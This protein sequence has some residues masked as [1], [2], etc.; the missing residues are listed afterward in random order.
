MTSELGKA[1]SL[2]EVRALVKHL[3]EKLARMAPGAMINGLTQVV[4]ADGASDQRLE[5]L[6]EFA[7]GIVSAQDLEKV[8]DRTLLMALKM[9][10]ADRAFLHVRESDKSVLE[11]MR[12]AKPDSNAWA[13]EKI[14]RA[15]VDRVR[16]A[17]EAVQMANVRADAQLG[18]DA[19]AYDVDLGPLVCLPMREG[20]KLL[21]ALY[22]DRR[23]GAEPFGAGELKIVRAI[24]SIASRAVVNA[25]VIAEQT[26]R[27]QHLEMLNKLYSAISRTLE[28]DQLLD[29]ITQITL[30]VTK[31]ER[32]FIL[33]MNGGQLRFGGGRDQGGPL[34]PQASRELSRSV[35]QKVLKTQEGVY[36]FDTS[37]DAEFS[38]KL[39]VVNLKLNS[40]VAVPLKGQQGLSGLIYIDSKTQSLTALEKELAILTNIANVASLAVDN[41]RLYRQATQ[42]GLTGLYVR[43]FFM[44]RMEE[45]AMR[46][47]RFGRI[48]SLL[49]MDIDH[50]KRFN[51]SYGHQTG[52]EVIKLVAQ[53]IK[54]AIRGGVDIPGRYGGEELVCMLP[55]TNLEGAVV[56]AERIR[57]QVETGGLTGPNGEPLRVTISIGVATFPAM[58]ETG[59]QLFERADQA[60]YMSKQNGR[61]KTTVY[62]VSG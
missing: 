33:L 13:A 29:Q 14:A 38:A 50:F 22:L 8:I 58:G 37:S 12:T 57:T 31:A 3:D 36:V 20:D 51:D 24:A 34:P 11:K 7:A 62:Q 42:D 18:D 49:V 56:V 10:G 25:Q 32:A 26:A 48:F 15:C 16:D 4:P 30:E 6:A 21:G 43:S 46:A 41:A 2:A 39:S 19:E 59:T 47:G 45:E 28:L 55:E 52:D 40:V 53:V 60:L 1:V 61:N 9:A 35:C 17:E 54:R 5:Q 23:T 44:V 27:R